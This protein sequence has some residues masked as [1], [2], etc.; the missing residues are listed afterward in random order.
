MVLD[1]RH[2]YSM[3]LKVSM[4]QPSGINGESINLCSSLYSHCHLSLSFCF[5]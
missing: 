2:Y 4:E 1:R 5:V 3:G